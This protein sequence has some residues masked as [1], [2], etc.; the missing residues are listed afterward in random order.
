MPDSTVFL[1][2]YHLSKAAAGPGHVVK[3]DCAK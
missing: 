2:P 1:V 3:G